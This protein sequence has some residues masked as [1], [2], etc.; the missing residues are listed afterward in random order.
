[1]K[2]PNALYNLPT[3]QFVS[4]RYTASERPHSLLLSNDVWSQEVFDKLTFAPNWDGPKNNDHGNYE[5][6]DIRVKVASYSSD[7]N[8]MISH[9]D[10]QVVKGCHQHK[11]PHITLHVDCKKVPKSKQ[12]NIYAAS[13]SHH[14][15]C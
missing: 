4:N 11:D 1:M 6:D 5:E 3:H 15:P 14:I 7:L 10:F 2:L 8:E 12:D 9:C 13:R